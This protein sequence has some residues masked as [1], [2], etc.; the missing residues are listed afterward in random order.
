MNWEGSAL[1]WSTHRASAS[2]TLTARNE[3][4]G[5]WHGNGAWRTPATGCGLPAGNRRHGV[6]PDVLPRRRRWPQPAKLNPV[7]AHARRY[8]PQL[9]S[10]TANPRFSF[11]DDSAG[12]QAATAYTNLLDAASKGVAQNENANIIDFLPYEAHQPVT[13]DRLARA[14]RRN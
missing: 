1:I 11:G 2:G 12:P 13:A 14:G 5:N 3:N 10:S 6:R 7:L 9:G 8:L 4:G